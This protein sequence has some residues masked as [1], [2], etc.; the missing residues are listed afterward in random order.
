[1][2]ERVCSYSS[3]KTEYS[4]NNFD[5]LVQ[6]NKDYCVWLSKEAEEF[7]KDAIIDNL[8]A[9]HA[10]PIFKWEVTVGDVQSLQQSIDFTNDQFKK[11]QELKEEKESGWFNAFRL[12]YIFIFPFLIGARLAI[13]VKK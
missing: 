1:M 6:E 10:N 4:P 3:I 9:F 13:L 8:W 12:M 7:K 5:Q 2:K 11:V